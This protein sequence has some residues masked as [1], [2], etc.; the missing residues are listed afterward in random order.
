MKIVDIFAEQ[1]FSFVYKTSEGEYD[2]NEDDRLMDLWTDVSYLR[3]YA[4]LN[5]VSNVNQFVNDR[6]RDAENIEDLLDELIEDGKP[7]EY[8]FRPLYDNEIDLK[9]LSL[10][11]GKVS[12]RDGLRLYAI[13]IDYNC[14]IITGGAIK[15]SQTMQEHPDTLNELLKIKKA[16]NY[17]KDNFV[18]D[19]DSFYEF[20]N[21][22][23]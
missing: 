8:Y 12:S 23:E 1:L 6:L 21:E 9:I 18:I 11:K 14:F 5:K 13:R 17:L 7:L 4:K 19:D 20:K 3:N 2:E 16:Q 22:L 15:M 10:Q